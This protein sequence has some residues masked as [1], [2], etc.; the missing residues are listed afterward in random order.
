MSDKAPVHDRISL[1]AMQVMLNEGVDEDVSGPPGRRRPGDPSVDRKIK[2]AEYDF[3]KRLDREL[4]WMIDRYVEL[5]L[6]E[7]RTPSEQVKVC[8]LSG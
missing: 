2:N 1:S 5:K 4:P 8:R 6:N 7:M 3:V